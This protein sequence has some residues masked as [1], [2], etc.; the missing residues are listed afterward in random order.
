MS[1]EPS[2]QHVTWRELELALA[3]IRSDI[4]GARHEIRELLEEVRASTILGPRGQ[5]IAR[6]VLGVTGA[7]VTAL[8]SY[9]LSRGKG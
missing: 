2:D 6:W 1:L 7:G 4:R 5:R 3:P 8:V 9:L